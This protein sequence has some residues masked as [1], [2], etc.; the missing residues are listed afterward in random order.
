[1]T[2][3]FYLHDLFI[4]LLLVLCTMYGVI[5]SLGMVDTDSFPRL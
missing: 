5:L 3:L 1:M 2:R 4:V